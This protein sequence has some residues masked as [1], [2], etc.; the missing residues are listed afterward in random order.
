MSNSPNLALPYIAANQAQK[1]VT[2]NDA[3]ALIDGM[4]QLSVVSRGLNA[5]PATYVDGNRFL[6]GAAP[7]LEW[8]GQ[9]A[10]IAFR[11]AGLWQFL[12]PRKGWAM[13]VEAESILL[14]YDGVN[15]VA[16]PVPQ[17]MQNMTLLG[18]NTTADATNKFAVNSSAVLLNNIGN[19]VQ[20]KL[21]KNAATDTASLLYQT[22]FSGRAEIGTT[23]DDGFHF[24]VSADGAA[25]KEAMAIDAA[26]G[27]GT[28]LANPTAAL[29]IATKQYVDAASGG[30]TPG[31]T[32][33]QVQFKNGT[34]FGGFTVGGDATLNTATG[35]LTISA[36]VVSNAKLATMA[37]LT[38]KGNN[39]GVAATPI[40]LTAAQVKTL[41]A[42]AAA[43]VAGLGALATAGT[44]NLSTQASGTLQAAQAPALNGDVTSTAG[45]LAT[46]ITAN[47]VTNAKLA[48]MATLTI[49]GNNTGT[50]AS[51]LDL[52]AAQVKSLLA[53]TTT[54]VTGLGALATLASV[55]L[56]TQVTGV[57]QAAQE[58]AHSGDVTNT[59]GS[60][61]L[62]IAANV[63]SNTKLAQMPALTFKGN[64]TA[65]AANAADLTASQMQAALN[66]NGLTAARFVVMN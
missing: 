59:A 19:G 41:L 4:L 53:I 25:W 33:G 31:G 62:T 61:A 36:G 27:L 46:A 26:S 55:N 3:V 8:L 17:I 50:A 14:V 42:I 28:V 60:L 6:I 13:W 58:P 52:T 48:T 2:H 57:L 51:P 10:M 1:H 39:S 64:A 18:V 23:G 15:W 35:A 9:A 40:D 65:A 16:P 34:V 49:K 29:G 66:I 30:S 47:A 21:N 5:P 56:S 11:N 20:V 44:L 32:A 22:G 12:T 37:T 7:T 54:D 24:K 45:S 43:D 63:V 38:L